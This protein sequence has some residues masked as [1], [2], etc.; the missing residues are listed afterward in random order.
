MVIQ[1]RRSIYNEEWLEREIFEVKKI[2]NTV[3]PYKERFRCQEISRKRQ[4]GIISKEE[5]A[6]IQK[7]RVRLQSEISRDHMLA[8]M[9]F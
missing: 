8:E 4:Q 2:V 1:E 7:S 9:K 3:I 6:L 5:I